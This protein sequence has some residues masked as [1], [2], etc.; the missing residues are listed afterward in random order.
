M[1]RIEQV[2]GAVANG[3]AVLG[4]TLLL[5][6]ATFTMLDGLLRAFANTPLDFVRELGDMVA[7]IA[8]AACLPI[9]LLRESNI[10]LRALGRVLPRLALRVVDGVAALVVEVVMIGM[11]WQ[12]WLHADKAMRA[13]EVTW[14]LEVPKAPF[15]FAVDG[16]LWVGV[17]VQL[18]VLVG[19]ARG[20]RDTVETE[21]PA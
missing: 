11:A 18:V 14:M 19:R 7:A 4:L 3:L 8:G 16:I 2:A 17:L 13:G 6:L 21:T 20:T 12:F 5:I 15:W 1:A 9:A 10:V